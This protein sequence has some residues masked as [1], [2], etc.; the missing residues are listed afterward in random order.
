MSEQ[1]WIER[2]QHICA[3]HLWFDCDTQRLTG[4]FIQ[5]RQHLVGPPVAQFV[6]HKVKAPDVIGMLRS[7]PDDRTVLVIQPPPLL[8][9]LRELQAFF[10]PQAFDLLV[11]DRPTFDAQQFGDLAVAVAPILLSQSDHCEA[12]RL[13]ILWRCPVL[14]RT[15]RQSRD[16]T[17]APFRCCQLLSGMHHG[18]TKLVCR[19]AF[20]FK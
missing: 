15:P 14:Q 11:I 20:G 2:I 12:Q 1:H 4:I 6:V 13:I 9:P 3:V 10:A 17:R 19:Q 7:E 8:V 16:L 18:L 5:Y